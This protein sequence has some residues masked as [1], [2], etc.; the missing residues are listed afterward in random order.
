MN[1]ENARQ[2][3]DL[4]QV[5]GEGVAHLRQCI[6]R[7]EIAPADLEMLGDMA[8]LLDAI[9]EWAE[10]Y[11]TLP[12][13]T[14]DIVANLKHYIIR[15]QACA[16][17]EPDTFVYDFRFHFQSLYR[18]LEYEIAYIVEDAVNRQDYPHLYPEIG[19]V[20]HAEITR[21]MEQE[22]CQ[23]S[24][25][26]LA[27]NN[28]AMTRD[29]VQSILDCTGDVDYE[30]ILV[31]NG[32]TDGVKE[33]F[34]S[35]PGAKV[36]HLPHNLHLVKGFNIGM[37]AAEGKYCAVVCNDFIFTPRWL[38]NLMACIQSDPEIGYVSPGAT[39]I[40]NDQQI[41]IP[42]SSI[43]AF[44]A[45]AEK[46]NIS[47]PRKWEERVVL[48]P[49]V[50]CCPTA[51]LRR[52]GYYDTRYFRGEFADD[53]I[54]LRIRRAGYKLIYCGD[55]VAHH[56]GSVTTAS[57]H[58]ANSMQEGRETFLR[59]YGLDAWDDA[60][61]ISF[62][63]HL[64]YEKM[65]QVR[66]ILGVDVKCGATLMQIKNRLWAQFGLRPAVTT[67][68]TEEKYLLD[69]QTISHEAIVL[70]TLRELSH[71]MKDK[72]DLVYIEKPL[73]CY[74]ENLDTIFESIAA[75]LAPKGQII[76]CINSTSSLKLIEQLVNGSSAVNNRKLYTSSFPVH[77]AILHGFDSPGILNMME[78]L[79]QGEQHRVK[80]LAE[81]LSR[82]GREQAERL[83]RR[84]QMGLHIYQMGYC[85][86]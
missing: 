86:L 5:G 65:L 8:A 85:G 71:K 1:R 67:A 77:K 69:L 73:D 55:T 48:L 70:D 39:S 24:V 50:L 63:R 31:D 59:R 75:V 51:L 34:E 40:S 46:Y 66:S 14:G 49:N 58:A 4:L 27:Y 26:V 11:A 30:L 10:R 18:I 57:D 12:H 29:C 9:R 16:A 56:Y 28:L 23:A 42:F 82:G 52:I 33:Y 43:A 6:R 62:Y 20:D 83:G 38:S 64:N 36:I 54:S 61:M 32:S 47:D 78:P 2:L 19:A 68:T 53:D 81:G 15:L 25:V 72:V 80:A 45:E 3:L 76:F 7:A 44:Q 22:A 84:L 17:D 79:D 37:M 21:Q 41:N 60:R 13:R 35:V 74:E